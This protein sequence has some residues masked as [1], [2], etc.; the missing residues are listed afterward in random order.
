MR[1]GA[2]GAAAV[3][4]ALGGAFAALSRLSAESRVAKSGALT[5]ALAMATAA[6]VALFVAAVYLALGCDERCD[7]SSGQWWDSAD[8]WQWSGQFA[9]A[10]A[11]T[12]GCVTAAFQTARGR[13]TR[14]VTVMTVS[15]V[16][17]AGWTILIAPALGD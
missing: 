1:P 10:A 15:V 3:A 14:A 17:F 7:R 12:A 11:A 9:L 8:A 16:C 2:L 6:V 13:H 4:L 5:Q